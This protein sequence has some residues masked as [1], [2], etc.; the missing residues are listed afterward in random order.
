[1]K[2]ELDKYLTEAYP[3]MFINR[4]EDVKITAMCWGFECKDGWFWLIDN[5]CKSI[6]SYID[7]N[8]HKN[9]PQVIVTQVKEK[10]G[11]L[12]FYYNGGDERING[13]VWLAENMSYNI[14]EKCGTTE[15]V[16]ST[17][18]WVRTLCENCAIEGEHISS[19]KKNK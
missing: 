15:N 14:C 17:K 7:N 4:Y 12:R 16:G 9:I 1:M 11:G 5:L 6:Q 10:F 19:W 18:K 8:S 3:K 13:M 2:I